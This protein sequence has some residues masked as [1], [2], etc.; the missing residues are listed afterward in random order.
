MSFIA[1]NRKKSKAIQPGKKFPIIQDKK[2][3]AYLFVD[4]DNPDKLRVH[5]LESGEIA[6]RINGS[7]KLF[8]G[9]ITIDRNS[10]EIHSQKNDSSILVTYTPE[11][12]I[13]LKD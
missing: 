4:E 8:I 6:L 5:I 10:F 13:S 11:N 1:D 2:T 9:N 3:V 12:E 7:S